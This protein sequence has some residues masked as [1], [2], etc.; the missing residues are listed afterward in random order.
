MHAI[1]YI[2]L[3]YFY[4]NVT[5]NEQNE[6]KKISS[7]YFFFHFWCT[8]FELNAYK[9]IGTMFMLLITITT[10]TYY[11]RA[12]KPQPQRTNTR[13]ERERQ[14]HCDRHTQSVMKMMKVMY[15]CSMHIFARSRMNEAIIANLTTNRRFFFSCV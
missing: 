4:M 3:E 7:V 6:K 11:H 2:V 15:I 10:S 14:R 9:V 8:V 1:K 5:L 13:I 12:E